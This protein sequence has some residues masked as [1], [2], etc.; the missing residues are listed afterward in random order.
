MNAPTDIIPTS[1]IAGLHVFIDEVGFT[2]CHIPMCLR[3]GEDQS[4]PLFLSV[5][6]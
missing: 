6:E 3:L 4:I 5:T 1:T 2:L